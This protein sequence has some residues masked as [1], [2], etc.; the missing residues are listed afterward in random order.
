M[1]VDEPPEDGMLKSMPEPARETSCGLSAAESVRVRVP[2][3]VPDEVGV[4][5]TWM[6]Q[7]PPLAATVVQLLVWAK[8]P[9]A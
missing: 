1:T 4:K 9:V 7:V 6:A 8:S 3:R 5:V 2:V